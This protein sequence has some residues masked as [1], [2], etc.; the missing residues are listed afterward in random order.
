MRVKGVPSLNWSSRLFCDVGAAE[1]MA[2]DD[3]DL[4]A[5]EA[6]I[7]AEVEIIV[8]GGMSPAIVSYHYPEQVGGLH[9]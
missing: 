8:P 1:L 3:V 6:D 2:E 7:A 4:F 9:A 5:E